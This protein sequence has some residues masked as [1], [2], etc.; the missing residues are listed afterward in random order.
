M[1]STMT[2]PAD[3]DL[4]PATGRTT[5]YAAATETAAAASLDVVVVSYNTRDLLVQCLGSVYA[6]TWA[7]AGRGLTV[8]VVDNGSTDGSVEAV[9]ERFPSARTIV[10][11]DNLGFSRANNLAIRQ[12]ASTY[13]LLLNPDTLV[14]PNAFNR[15]AEY[16]ER[17][18][19]VGM[20]S[21]KLVTGE[22]GLDLACRRSFPTLWDGFCRASGLSSWFPKSRAFARYNLTYLP[23]DETHEVDAVNGA[24]M[25]VRRPALEGVGLL[26]ESFFMYGEDLDWCYRFK[27]AGW[28]VVYHPA[29]VTVHYK[30]KSSGPR[31]EKM[32]RVFFDANDIFMRKHLFP[33][34]SAAWRGAAL[35]ANW[36]W[37][38]TTVLKNRLRRQ[39]RVRP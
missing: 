24:F 15:M 29:A 26:D 4:L 10:P 11:G 37:R 16:L 19:A 2:L 6:S 28:K 23:E 17:H 39:K 9:R 21:C 35:S 34:R 33:H 32:I 25:F 27:A 14:A 18:P 1:N 5:A 31:S 7:S 36:A 20:V 30:G 38:T 8:W 22:G 12:C 3:A 13:L